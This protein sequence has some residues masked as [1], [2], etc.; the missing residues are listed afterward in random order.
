VNRVTAAPRAKLSSSAKADDPVLRDG[1]FLPRRHGV[2]DT[3]KE[4]GIRLADGE[5]RWRGMTGYIGGSELTC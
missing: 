1:E 4:P 5:T 3:P 2:P